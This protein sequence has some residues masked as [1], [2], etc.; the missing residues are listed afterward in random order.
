MN[1]YINKMIADHPA[2]LL[3]IS[4]ILIGLAIVFVGTNP[5]NIGPGQVQIL[6]D[7]ELQTLK[8]I[9]QRTLIEVTI[10]SINKDAPNYY[11]Y[12]SE[13]ADGTEYYVISLYYYN[14][15]PGEKAYVFIVPAPSD[16]V[17]RYLI[18]QETANLWLAKGYAI[19]KQ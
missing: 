5:L 8:N 14:F 6:T 10:I 19:L 3:I 1:K 17:I 18:D 16:G 13:S 7:S 9:N 2:L 12:K 15:K 11:N 4:I